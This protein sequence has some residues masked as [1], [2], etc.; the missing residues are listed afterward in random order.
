MVSHLVAEATRP[1]LNKLPGPPRGPLWAEESY[2]RIIRDEEHLYR[3]IQYIGRNVA[4]AGLPK[5][6]WYRWIDP[7]WERS[8][9]GFV[10]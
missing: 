1:V 3:V 7:S 2:D 4:K 5:S 8:G 9:W 10:T 6:H